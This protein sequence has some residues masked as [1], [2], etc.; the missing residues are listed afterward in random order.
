MTEERKR[1]PKCGKID[2]YIV[3]SAPIEGFE[4]IIEFHCACGHKWTIEE[5]T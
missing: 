1:C 4:G 5:E 3:E 2:R